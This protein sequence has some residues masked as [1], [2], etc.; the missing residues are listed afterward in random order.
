M[1]DIRFQGARVAVQVLGR[2]ELQGI[3]EDRYNDQVGD[4]AGTPHEGEV[5]VVQGSQRGN[6]GDAHAFGTGIRCSRSQLG[7]GFSY[8]NGH[9]S[10][11]VARR[12]RPVRG[13]PAGA[14]LFRDVS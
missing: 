11:L 2:A 9:H 6:E 8:G 3:H 1:G 10:M 13:S 4:L 14:A 7:H 12:R 5:T